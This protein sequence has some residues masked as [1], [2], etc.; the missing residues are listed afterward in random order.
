MEIEKIVKDL[1]EQGL[2]GD[3]LINALQQMVTEGKLAEDDFT[4][5]KNM[6]VKAD[7]KARA[8]KLFDIKL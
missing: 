8:E 3:K 7:E 1:Q 4:K 2:Q 5:A 6:L